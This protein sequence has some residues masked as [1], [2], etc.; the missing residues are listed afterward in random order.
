V[1]ADS[2]PLGYAWPESLQDDVGAPAQGRSEVGIALA[3]PDDRLLAGVQ[4]GIPAGGDRSQGIA[5][6]RFDPDDARTSP[7]ELAACEGAGQVAREI[8]DQQ[9]A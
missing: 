6:G 5:L 3:I 2:E 8:D 7:Q 9:V 1:C 4:R